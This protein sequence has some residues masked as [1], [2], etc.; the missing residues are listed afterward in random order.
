[1]YT[2]YEPYRALY[3]DLLEAEVAGRGQSTQALFRGGATGA[4]LIG[5]GLLF[6]ASPELPFLVFAVLTFGAL[7]QF[8]RS[9]S[10][11]RRIRHQEEHE[12]GRC[13]RPRAESWSC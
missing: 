12:P 3:P 4:A 7:V 5:G 6:G 10:G 8:A 1:Y 2:A 13:V 9:A 11:S